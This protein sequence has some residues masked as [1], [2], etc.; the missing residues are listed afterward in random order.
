M[1]PQLLVYC[2]EAIGKYGS[3]VSY[4]SV[5]FY[6]EPS[7]QPLLTGDFI[8]TDTSTTGAIDFSEGKAEISAFTKYKARYCFQRT[9]LKYEGIPSSW[10]L[11]SKYCE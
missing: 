6:A 1:S 9:P 2:R 8:F 10:E 7:I 4:T 11:R 5:G 3:F